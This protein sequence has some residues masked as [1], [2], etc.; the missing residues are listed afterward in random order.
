MTDTTATPAPSLD[1]LIA[2]ERAAA[3]LSDNA[4][5]AML[6]HE[7]GSAA[8]ARLAAIVAGADRRVSEL[9]DQVRNHPDHTYEGL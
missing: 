6:R 2:A 8:G 9:R 4:Y 3:E 5:R 7:P 1:T